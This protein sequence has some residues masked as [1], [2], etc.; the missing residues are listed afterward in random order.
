MKFGLIFFFCFCFFA[1][2]M[3]SKKHH[4]QLP[5]NFQEQQEPFLTEKDKG[6]LSHLGEN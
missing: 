4:E 6:V 1:G 3:L 2:C 5:K